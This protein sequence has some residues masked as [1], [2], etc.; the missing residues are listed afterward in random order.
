MW[1]SAG[2]ILP[3][4]TPTSAIRPCAWVLNPTTITTIPPLPPCPIPV[5]RPV[6]GGAYLGPPLR[7]SH[8]A[9]RLAARS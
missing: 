7:T 3:F 2:L 4:P 5:P 6:H 9:L 1:G 8:A